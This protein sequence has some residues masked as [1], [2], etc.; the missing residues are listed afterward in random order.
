MMRLR[1]DKVISVEFQDTQ[2]ILSTL[3]LT[4]KKFKII[5]QQHIPLTNLEVA[6][7]IIFNQSNIASF[8][9]EFMH[10]H[11]LARCK[12]YIFAPSTAKNSIPEAFLTLQKTLC[13]AKTGACVERVSSS[14]LEMH[15]QAIAPATQGLRS[16]FYSGNNLLTILEPPKTTLPKIILLSVFSLFIVGSTLGYCYQQ[17]IAKQI[18]TITNANSSLTT[19]LQALSCKQKDLDEVHISN[20]S[21]QKAIS[22]FKNIRTMQPYPFQ[23]LSV[24]SQTIPQQT[25]LTSLNVGQEG[26]QISKKTL[27]EENKPQKLNQP[28]NKKLPI[29][30]HGKTK[31]AHEITSFIDALTNQPFLKK[32][33]LVSI[34]KIKHQKTK[35]LSKKKRKSSFCYLF[36]VSALFADPSTSN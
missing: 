6:S 9:K 4:H 12:A 7:G 32:V 14:S 29:M 10:N 15:L 2:L 27:P 30:L 3:Q 5:T 36:Q 1:P 20:A 17:N 16:L 26:N 31:E 25:V 21:T 28:L 22:K 23:L 33:S 19:S 18:T 8:I 35:S 24:I 11:N 34:N 13:V